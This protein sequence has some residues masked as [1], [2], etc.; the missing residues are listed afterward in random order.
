MATRGIESLSTPDRNARGAEAVELAVSV[1]LCTYQGE[2]FLPAQLDSL[3]AQT[4]L[5]H[6]IVL[7]DDASL[8]GTWGLLQAFAE[9][10]H[11]L[12]I[13]VRCVRHPRNL[14]FVKHFEQALGLA[15]GELIFLCDQDDV[16]HAEKIALMRRRFLDDPALW[17]LCSDARLIDANGD[18]LGHSLFEALELADEERQSVHQGRAFEV[19]VRRSMVT[20]ATA[21]FRK[22]LLEQALPIAEGWV[23]DEWL[24]IVAAARGKL[25]AVERPLIGYRQHGG[26]QI[27]M[28]RRTLQ[29]KWRDLK[30]A[31]AAQIR[32]EIARMR[33]LEARLADGA[34]A[35]VATAAR[36]REHFERRMDIGQRW[37]LARLPA[38]LR[39]ARRGDYHRYGTGVRSMLRDFLRHD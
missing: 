21:A 9:R 26:N 30:R 8:D 7:S 4:M 19:L 39:E 34:P 17:L 27:G 38:I 11:A 32:A 1:V 20:G 14:G 16:W 33:M 10:A 35:C 37:R 31:R 5:P 29:D 13:R 6:E 18:D 25:D 2:R 15:S 12:G 22:R 36:R 3:L 28:A 23:H 24:A